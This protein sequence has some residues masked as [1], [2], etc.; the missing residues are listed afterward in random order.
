MLTIREFTVKA[1]KIYIGTIWDKRI[2]GIA[3]SLDGRK[4]LEDR[5]Q[6]LAEFLRKRGVRVKLNTKDSEY[7]EL[8]Y[9][10]LVGRIEN[11]E[12]LDK[13]S[14]LGVTPFERRVYEWLVKNVKR[15]QVVTYGELAKALETSPRAIGNAMKRNPYPIVVPCHRVISRKN[16]FM[17]TPKPEYKKFLLEVEGWIN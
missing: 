11:H 5:I 10:T 15:G 13:L 2:L 17:Y 12:M 1:K 6:N 3:F 14:F 7:P 4:F 9:Q 16:P 8:V